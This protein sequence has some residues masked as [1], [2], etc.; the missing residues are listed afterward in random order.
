VLAP[1]ASARVRVPVGPAGK[2]LVVP[3]SALRKGPG[4]DH[5]FV[6]VQDKEGKPRAHLRPVRSGPVV[7]G[8]VLILTGLSAGERVASSGSFK[9]REAVLVAIATD[10]AAA[11]PAGN[12]GN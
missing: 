12:G 11:A 7:G 10:S 9:L 2:A 6:I 4:G 5:V 8:E 1:G 3:V